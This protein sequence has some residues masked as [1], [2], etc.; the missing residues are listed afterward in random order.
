MT[1]LFSIFVCAILL[2]S[3]GHVHGQDKPWIDLTHELSSDAVFW[4]TADPF[5][6][7]TDFEGVTE[8]GYYY[9]AY[10]FATAEHGGTHIDAPVHFAEGKNHVSANHYRNLRDSAFS[11]WSRV[12]A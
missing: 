10:S 7:T 6:M 5:K 12:L 9:S 3:A 1:P 2:S 8:R 11:Q 4:P